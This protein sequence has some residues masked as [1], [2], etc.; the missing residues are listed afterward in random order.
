[1]IPAVLEKALWM[2]TLVVLH[3]KGQVTAKE[4]TVNAASHGLLGV[5]FAVAFVKTRRVGN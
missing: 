3:L 4:L 1:M 5:L 2:V